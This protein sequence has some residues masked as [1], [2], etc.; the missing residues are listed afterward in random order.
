M[1]SSGGLFDTLSLPSRVLLWF[2]TAIRG[3]IPYGFFGEL[4]ALWK[5][6]AAV[7]SVVSLAIIFAS[8]M[9]AFRHREK[10]KVRFTKKEFKQHNLAKDAG[11]KDDVW[12]GIVRKE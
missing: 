7:I 9:L 1:N 12:V 10:I 8:L 4:L 5:A 3:E 2:T 6:I 11:G